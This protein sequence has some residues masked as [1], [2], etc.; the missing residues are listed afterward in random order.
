MTATSGNT[1]RLAA[2]VAPAGGTAYDLV[3]VP[4]ADADGE[5]KVT[6]LARDRRHSTKREVMVNVAADGALPVGQA[7]A[8]VRPDPTGLSEQRNSFELDAGG[9]FQQPPDP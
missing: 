5:V 1:G 4:P 8:Y 7:A 3:L 9:L 6:V 2:S